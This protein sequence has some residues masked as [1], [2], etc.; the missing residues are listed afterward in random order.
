MNSAKRLLGI[1]EQL[2]KQQEN[3]PMVRIWAGVFDLD[4]NSSDLE[5]QVNTCLT[6]LRGQ[7]DLVKARLIAN[8]VTEDLLNPGF[9]RFRSVALPSQLASTWHG[10]R[11]NVRAAENRVILKWASWVLRNEEEGDVEAEDL[12]KILEEITSIEGKLNE[13]QI[14]DYLRGFI[15]EQLDSIKLAL[16]TYKIQ[17]IKPIEDALQNAVGAYTMAGSVIEEEYRKGDKEAKT[18]LE[19]ASGLLTTTAEVCDKVEKVSKFGAN[20]YV[21]G[22]KIYPLIKNILGA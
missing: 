14:S 16:S 10:H 12:K 1:Y 2:V 21:L 20:A 3:L 9:A 22:Q 4:V 15:K 8:G 5:D 18:L 17:G 6:A 13:S 7:I 11:E 19:R